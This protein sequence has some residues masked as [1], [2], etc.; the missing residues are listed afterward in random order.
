M[1]TPHN[2][3]ETEH[4]REH[5]VTHLWLDL[6]RRPTENEVQDH[7][8]EMDSHGATT[9]AHL[10]GSLLDHEVKVRIERQKAEEAAKN[11]KDESDRAAAERI[12]ERER[13]MK[14]REDAERAALEAREN[15]TSPDPSLATMSNDGDN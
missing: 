12:L 10:V 13:R 7:L 2:D 1:A 11:A 9:G 5:A 3:R 14:E 4:R 8:A 15:E 6:G